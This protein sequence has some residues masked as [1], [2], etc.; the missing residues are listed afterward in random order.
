MG[1]RSLTGM[2]VAMLLAAPTSKHG[3]PRGTCHLVML[4]GRHAAIIRKLDEA[5]WT[6]RIMHCTKAT[7]PHQ[8]SAEL[9]MGTNEFRHSGNG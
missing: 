2:G 8:G 3:I 7:L 4:S 9:F 1:H 6:I 5:T